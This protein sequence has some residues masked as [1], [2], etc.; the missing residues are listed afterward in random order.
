MKNSRIISLFLLIAILLTSCDINLKVPG[1]GG[2]G[3]KPTGDG[4]KPQTPGAPTQ[5]AV[6]YI[7][8]D[9]TFDVGE[10]VYIIVGISASDSSSV[11]TYNL[12]T[13]ISDATGV[14]GKILTD[15]GEQKPNEIT[16]GICNREVAKLGYD[17]L[18]DVTKEHNK[19]ARYGFYATENAVAIVYDLVEGYEKKIINMAVEFFEDECIKYD[20][21]VDLRPNLFR[22]KTVDLIEYQAAADAERLEA[23]WEG[24]GQQAGEE[25]LEALKE[26]Y[27]SFYHREQLVEW[28]ANLFD[29]AT[30]GFYYSNSARDNDRVLYNGKY[31]PLLPDIETTSQAVGF[32]SSSG[33]TY[34]Y[35]NLREALPG[36]LRLSIIKFIKEKQ[37]P[38][39]CFYH[40]Q[41]THEMVDNQLSR[42]ARDMTKGI[43][44]LKELGALPT[45]DTPTGTDGDGKLWN[46]TPVS[47][48]SKLTTPISES[49]VI[50]V[51]RV[52]AAAVAVPSH[53]E[54]DVAFRK[55]LSGL[56]INGN[57]YWVGN[58]IASQTSEIKERDKVLKGKGADYSLVDILVEWMDNSCYETTGHWKKVADYEGLNGLMKIS[59]A[60]ESLGAP[61]PYPVQAAKSAIATITMEDNISGS[62]VCWVYNS[63]FAINNVINNVKTHK[64]GVEADEIIGNIRKTLRDNAAELIRAT[65][66]KQGKFMCE[67]GSFSYTV[68][69]SSSTSQGMPVAIPGTKEGDVNATV[70]C[71]TGTIG[72][73]MNA[74]GYNKVPLLTPSDF[75]KYIAII[76]ENIATLGASYH[77]AETEED[78]AADKINFKLSTHK[79]KKTGV[80]APV[81]KVYNSTLYTSESEQRNILKYIISSD[82]GVAAGLLESDIDYYIK[83][84]KMHNYAAERP[85]WVAT[86]LG[87]TRDEVVKSAAHVDLN[88]NDEHADVYESFAS[89]LDTTE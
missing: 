48:V 51:S 5:P 80:T 7:N 53:L 62:T 19:V 65:A 2:D 40:P 34:G 37:D 28:F 75:N 6:D 31:Y 39:G 60:Y 47:A 23:A 84:W 71:T 44:T 85:G 42:R 57:S 45:Y 66:A 55:Y 36:W 49:S 59:A 50:A 17:R 68:A 4:G 38:N 89:M 87:K 78:L 9:I 43:G 72:N 56:D 27:E 8:D 21:A 26:M 86:I 25:A 79:N 61:L 16:L 22:Y 67:D 81:I 83:E 11:D 54:D 32:I 41:W 82:A 88:T 63:W 76:E 29:P 69:G 30:G 10:K 52:V 74:F 70:I 58:Q 12:E 73:M 35:S 1:I 46:G 24:F 13:I 3:D 64:G 14:Y 18:S 15:E 77:Y 20:T 33:M